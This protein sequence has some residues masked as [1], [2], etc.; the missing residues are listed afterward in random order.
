MATLADGTLVEDPAPVVEPVVAPAADPPVVE[1]I[2]AALV[3]TPVAPPVDPT[4]MTV[5]QLESALAARDAEIVAVKETKV[6]LQNNQQL[7]A[8]ET[9]RLRSE[10][11][12]AV[13]GR[14]A[15][16]AELT[17][18]TEEATAALASQQAA[19]LQATAA[20][21]SIEADLQNEKAL[22]VKNEVMLNDYP[23][24]AA[25]AEIIAPNADPEVIRKACKAI[26]A[27]NEKV[28][29]TQRQVLAAGAPVVPAGPARTAQTSVVDKARI[30]GY[31]A[32][33]RQ[34]S[35]QEYDR[36][37]AIVLEELGG[38]QPQA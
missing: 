25:Y 15:I 17:K 5:E 24:L 6:A 2:A 32:E 14:T 1:P 18:R 4:K 30:K 35:M 26:L 16:D 33:G 22:R 13:E 8:A 20:T 34:I 7:T 10:L 11:A 12:K 31:L 27:A 29:A 21:T 38:V 23:G 19:T 9:D 36:R 37:R 3:A 28:M